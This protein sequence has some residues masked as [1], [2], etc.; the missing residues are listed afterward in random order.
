MIAWKNKD[1]SIGAIKFSD[2]KKPALCIT[3]GSTAQ[4]Y[5]YFNNDECATLFMQTLEELLGITTLD[6]REVEQNE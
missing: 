1:V 6:K 2:R 5:G 3:E 4:V